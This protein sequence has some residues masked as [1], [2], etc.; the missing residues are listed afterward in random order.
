MQSRRRCQMQMHYWIFPTHAP[1]SLDAVVMFVI[2][3]SFVALFLIL[4]A[5]S[6]FFS[7]CSKRQGDWKFPLQHRDGK[8]HAKYLDLPSLWTATPR[9]WK[10]TKAL[11][12]LWE[13]KGIHRIQTNSSSEHM[14]SKSDSPYNSC[15]KRIY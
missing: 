9:E 11:C 8:K 6:T 14:P 15:K 13:R 10:D 12:N 2:L 5:N 4:L 3:T 7:C 1:K